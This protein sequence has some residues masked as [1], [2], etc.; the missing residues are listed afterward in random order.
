[1][2]STITLRPNVRY[3]KLML[4]VIKM[5]NIS[6]GD[7]DIENSLVD[8]VERGGWNDIRKKR[9]EQTESSTETYTLSM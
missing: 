9:V 1:M 7:I 2:I 6:N 4:L 8:T 3:L 5:R